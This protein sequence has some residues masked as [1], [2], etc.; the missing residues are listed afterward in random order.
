MAKKS[1][2]AVESLEAEQST[3]A[4]GR[5][6][7]QEGLEGSFPA[8]DPVSATTTAIPSGLTPQSTQRALGSDAPRVDEALETIL[9]HRNDPYVEPRE[10]VAALKEELESL[11]YRVTDDLRNKIRANPWQAV[12]VG[13][14]IGFLVGL[15]R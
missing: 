3:G 4:P 14:A 6:N 9:K 10:E 12:A 8:S 5:E 2:P 7:L 13:G 1:S 11:R 15:T